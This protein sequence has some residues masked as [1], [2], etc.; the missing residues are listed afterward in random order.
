MSPILA[1]LINWLRFGGVMFAFQYSVAVRNA[2]LDSR[3]TTI[4]TSPVLKIFSGAEPANCAAA[5]PAGL[6]V[7]ITLPADWMA[8]ASGGVKDKIG[9]WSAAA[10]GAGTAASF[11]IYDSGL[12][13][14][15]MQGN[16]TATGGGGDMTVDNVSVAAGQTVTVTGATGN[17]FRLTAGNA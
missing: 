11:R 16:V 13:A 10:S 4:G 15:H 5:D 2:G 8:A 14:C 3:E 7:S 17:G 1:W 9:T 6:L 12:T